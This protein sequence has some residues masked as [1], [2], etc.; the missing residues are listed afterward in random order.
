MS[1]FAVKY[2]KIMANKNNYPLKNKQK[3]NEKTKPSFVSSK[4]ETKK[5]KNS[6][7]ISKTEQFAVVAITLVAFIAIAIVE[8]IQNNSDT[9]FMAQSRSMFTY[10]CE[11]FEQFTKA[12]GSLIAWLGCYFTQFFYEPT[13]GASI[14]IGFWCLLF[15]LIKKA[16]R[17]SNLWSVLI[18]IPLSLLLV[19]IIY[20][21]YWIYYIKQPGYWFRETF[22][23]IYTMGTVFAVSRLNKF[24]IPQSILSVLLISV[25]YY[26]T[27]YYAILAAVL[28]IINEWCSI[29]KQSVVNTSV[30]TALSA[31]TAVVT[32]FA[33]Y[34]RFFTE[35]R[36][37][38]IFLAG[39][40]R[41]QQDTL[42]D[43]L[44]SYP[45]VA[46]AVILAILP[47]F[48]LLVK[49]IKI[50]GAYKMV[51]RLGV[52][53]ILFG[54]WSF[55]DKQDFKDYNYH[56]ELRMYDAVDNCRWDDVLDESA[57]FTQHAMEEKQE[58]RSGNPTREMVIFNHIALLNKG[59]MGNQMFKFNNFG[60]A[61]FVPDTT[62]VPKTEVNAEGIEE[63][64]LNDNGEQKMDTMYLK[65]HMVQT[66]GP[67]IYYYHGKTNF[68]SRWC[69]ENSV[70][71]G[72]SFN[73]TKILARCAL[74]NGEWDVAKKYLDILEKSMYYK[75]W[76]LKYKPIITDHKKIKNF[77]EF[78]SVLELYNHMGTVLDGDQGL[79]EM[80]L[81][82]YF[83]NTMNKDSKLMQELTLNYAMINKDIQLFWPRFFLYAQL[84]KDKK[85][86]IHYQEAAYLYGNLEKAVDI[87]HMPFDDTIKQGY[88]NFQQESQSMLQRGMSV[89]QVRDMME[90]KYGGT[91]YWFYFF[92]RDVKSY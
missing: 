39:F 66:A 61:P 1:N 92:C 87:T 57:K 90:P 84:H 31:V 81:L 48:N 9:L 49:N 10:G 88:A 38:D 41:F 75:D 26:Y 56:A 40:P 74:I 80:Y 32:P 6:S 68:A 91:F 47:I 46:I 72:Y 37:E 2:T 43:N 7:P 34:S 8:L 17:L 11:F 23:L 63:P 82:N 71:F 83:S 70:E 52:I 59:T 76:A 79:C 45:F 14:L 35:I 55:V 27:G 42:T 30:V 65:V 44:H 13:L 24:V 73:E 85:M 29:K 19:S 58:G 62:F 67:M 54:I 36:N 28:I 86:P 15:F 18:V 33:C 4:P 78:D 77:H 16:F 60:D 25:G 3:A 20:N 69:I 64:V 21:G 22:G 5:S 50:T 89:E 53:A 12:P 51:Y